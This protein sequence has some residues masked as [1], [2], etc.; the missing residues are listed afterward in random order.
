MARAISLFRCADCAHTEPRWHGRCAG[1]GGWNTLVEE[2]VAAS[3]AP[4]RGVGASAGPPGVRPVR[5][6]DVSSPEVPRLR[7]AIGEL[8]RVLGGGTVSY[9]H[10]RAHETRH[11]LVCRLLLEKK[12]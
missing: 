10:L 9:T 2:A 5:L 8:D 7:T 1:C 3:A 6:R 12:K 4:R 11:E